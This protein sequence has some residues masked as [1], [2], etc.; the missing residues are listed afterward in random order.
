ML[1]IPPKIIYFNICTGRHHRRTR[2]FVHISN[3]DTGSIY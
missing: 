3:F 1:D 2:I